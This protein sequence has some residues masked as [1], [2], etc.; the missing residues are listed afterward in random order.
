MPPLLEAGQQQLTTADANEARLVTKTRWIVES[1]NGHL[2]SIFKLL[3]Q[4]QQIQVLPNIGD[5][6]RIGG[7]IINSRI[8]TFS[9]NSKIASELVPSIHRDRHRIVFEKAISLYIV[10]NYPASHCQ[11]KAH[12]GAE[13]INSS[14][15]RF[16]KRKSTCLYTYIYVFQRAA[17]TSLYLRTLEA[18]LTALYSRTLEAT[19][20]I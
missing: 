13:K 16:K 18:A 6:I 19:L 10:P 2:K 8:P 7:A 1:R 14:I 15:R 3:N 20:M 9:S 4:V 11:R 17:S 5:F 12:F